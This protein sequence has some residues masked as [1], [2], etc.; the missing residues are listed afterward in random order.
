MGTV[1]SRRSNTLGRGA[2][3]ADFVERGA[4]DRA[5]VA[6]AREGGEPVA[7]ERGR[8]RCRDARR[9]LCARP[10]ADC[11][12]RPAPGL[13]EPFSGGVRAETAVQPSAIRG[14][15]VGIAE[16]AV[17]RLGAR[18]YGVD[19]ASPVET[20]ERRPGP[21][22]TASRRSGPRGVGRGSGREQHEGHGASAR[23]PVASVHGCDEPVAAERGRLRCRVSRCCFGAR[24]LG[25]WCSWGEC[26]HAPGC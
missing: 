1:C 26:S 7:T 15:G 22:D 14:C 9:S 18:E 11:T 17:R 5:P 20:E 21:A 19:I 2:D 16:T 13:V 25:A 8:S 10:R 3:G 24:Q 23:G 6:A 4:H 12:P